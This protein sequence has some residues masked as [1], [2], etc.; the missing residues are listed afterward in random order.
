MPRPEQPLAWTEAGS[1]VFFDQLATVPDSAFRE[2][3]TLP[4]WTT[5]HL[6]AHVGYNAKALSRLVH[7]ARTGE[8]T[9]AYDSPDA[10][11]AEID[12]GAELPAAALRELVR[13]A[14]AQ[15]LADF[16][17]LTAWDAKVRNPQGKPIS[18]SEVPWLRTREMWIHTVDLGT[19]VRF[20]DFPGGLV[21]A[22]ITD[23]IGL[24][25]SRAD[26]PALALHPSDRER[27]WRVDIAGEEAAVVRGTAAELCRWLAGRGGLDAPELSRWL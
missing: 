9:P 18:A 27:E 10:R 23:I 2:P 13:E 17:E 12:K 19:G 15:L 25:Q 20:E 22:L 24:R 26:G 4:G 3:S 16:A 6:V 1:R 14:D 8:E 7:W 11:N 21:D 5:A